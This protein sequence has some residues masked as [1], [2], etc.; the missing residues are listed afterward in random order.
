MWLIMFLLLISDINPRI[1]LICFIACCICQGFDSYLNYKLLKEQH[2][3]IDKSNNTYN[4]ILKNI[5]E[6]KTND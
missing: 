5:V 6:R 2:Q 4:E 1:I 3:L